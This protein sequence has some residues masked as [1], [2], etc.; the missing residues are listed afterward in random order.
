MSNGTCAGGAFSAIL[1][2]GMT[3]ETTRR[4]SAGQRVEDLCRAC[5]AIRTHTVMA[6]G[7]VPPVVRVVCGYC[8]S[9]HNY[10]GGEERAR[11]TRTGRG[12][13]TGEPA[14]AAHRR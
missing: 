2:T 5:G 6:V 3:E 8:G 13:A 11:A 1:V 10:R 7:I 9:Q 12:P 14:N 4:F